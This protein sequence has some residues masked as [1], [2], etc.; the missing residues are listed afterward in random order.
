MGGQG[1]IAN[2]SGNQRSSMSMAFLDGRPRGLRGEQSQSETARE[3]PERL[4][5]KQ[6]LVTPEG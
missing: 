5:R 6:F 2:R 4:G 1:T 3:L